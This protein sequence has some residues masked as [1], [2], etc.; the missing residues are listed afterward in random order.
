M[1]LKEMREYS[2]MLSRSIDNNKELLTDLI[3]NWD[4]E[5]IMACLGTFR[6]MIESDDTSKYL[7]ILV[8]QQVKQMAL[9]STLALQVIVKGILDKNIFLEEEE[10][11]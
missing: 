4:E 8:S 2:G 5:E 11:Q 10:S 6:E 7:K 1:E 3:S 9:L